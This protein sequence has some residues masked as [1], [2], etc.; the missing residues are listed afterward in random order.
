MRFVSSY[1]LLFFLNTQLTWAQNPGQNPGKL[2]IIDY[3]DKQEIEIKFG[4]RLFTKYVYHDDI[5]KPVLY[6]IYTGSGKMVTR[7]YPLIPV[8][9]ER[10]DHPHHLGLWLNYGDVN[11]LDFWNNSSAIP[12]EKKDHYGEIRHQKITRIHTEGPEGSLDIVAN[13]N[14]SKKETLLIEKTKFEFSQ[15]GHTIIIDRMTTLTAQKD[16]SFKDNKEGMI[17]IRVTR[18]LELPA[19]KPEIFTDA[20]GNP[21]EV[22]VLN[23]EGV[24]GEYLS[25]TGI[26]GGDVWGTRAEW[27][28]LSGQIQGEEVALTII[29][30]PKNPGYPTYW[31]ARGYGLFAANT[32]GQNAFD[33][34]QQL[35][36]Q[37]SKGESATFRYRVLV[38]DSSVLTANDIDRFRTSFIK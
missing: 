19:D 22:K 15:I 10:S 3:P 20:Q 13:W 5:E 2:S 26:T 21:T 28:R 37:L 14:N 25:S 11:G 7:G 34:K 24:T 30:H 33:K 27:V 12:N 29:D 36:F 4:D 1:L 23:N 32:L 8:A 9:G 18:A 17:G 6:P 35:N 38:H 16:I 31:H